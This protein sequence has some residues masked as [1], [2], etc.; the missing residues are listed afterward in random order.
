MREEALKKTGTK[1]T[2]IN[3]IMI[4]L[5]LTMQTTKNGNLCWSILEL[6]QQNLKIY[7]LFD[8]IKSLS[9]KY[10][11]TNFKHFDNRDIIE[12]SISKTHFVKIEYSYQDV[13]HKC[14]VYF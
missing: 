2:N 7:I 9:S 5:K 6:E 10:M 8:I 12:P 14:K 13:L 1:V 4:H 11:M 3:G